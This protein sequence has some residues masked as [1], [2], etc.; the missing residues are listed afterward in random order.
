MPGDNHSEIDWTFYVPKVHRY[1]V[2]Y[3]DAY[4]EDDMLPIE[5]PARNPWH[6]GIYVTRIPGIPKLDFHLEGV[7]TEQQ[8]AFSLNDNRGQ[9]NYWNMTYR[10]GYTNAGNLIGNT[11]GRDGR[12]IQAWFNYWFSA[13]DTLRFTYRHN[14]VASDFL[15]G[16]GAWQ[17]YSVRND[18]YLKSGLYVKTE[19]Q[20]E[21]ISRF[22]ALFNGPK[23]NFTA[24]VEVGFIPRGKK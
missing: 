8:G 17:D 5:N 10:D 18:A 13:Q 22:P 11:V 23:S 24:V 16:G 20:Y 19:L 3:G 15:P 6:P 7:S 4:A 12:T 21:N 1:F 14:A 2:L 9:F